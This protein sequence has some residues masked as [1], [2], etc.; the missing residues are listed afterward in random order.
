MTIVIGFAAQPFL[1][2]AADAAGEITDPR[3]YVTAV[4]GDRP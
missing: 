2:L 4:L 3:A 1:R